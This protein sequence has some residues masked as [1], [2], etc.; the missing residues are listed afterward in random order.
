MLKNKKIFFCDKKNLSLHH[1][2]MQ[3]MSNLTKN[4][5]FI[6]NSLIITFVGL[7]A[8]NPIYDKEFDRK[9]SANQKDKDEFYKTVRKLK[10]NRSTQPEKIK[11]G[12]ENIKIIVR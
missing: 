10:K 8:S 7:F 6:I 2:T 12:E 11:I 1:K 4:M 9:L 5:S 3:I